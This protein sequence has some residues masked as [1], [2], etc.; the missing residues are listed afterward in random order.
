[1]HHKRTLIVK[2]PTFTPIQEA[3]NKSNKLNVALGL[4]HQK[5]KKKKSKV[6]LLFSNY[7]ECFSKK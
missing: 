3:L 7:N 5:K 4:T 2:A 1:M 6:F